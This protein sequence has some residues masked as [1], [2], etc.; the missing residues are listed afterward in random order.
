[1]NLTQPITYVLRKSNNT[2]RFHYLPSSSTTGA[3]ITGSKSK[4]NI[5]KSFGA[6]IQSWKP[7]DEME[8]PADAPTGIALPNTFDHYE[9][10]EELLADNKGDVPSTLE[11]RGAY[12]DDGTPQYFV[13]GM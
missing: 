2:G 12:N 1:M 11:Y 9:S 8:L 7:S 6:S 13:P 3:T 5:L 10:T 4:K